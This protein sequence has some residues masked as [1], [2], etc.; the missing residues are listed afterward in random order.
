M[1]TPK[2]LLAKSEKIFF[3]VVSSQ[4]MGEDIFPLVIP[5]NKEISGSNYSDWKN[6]LVPLHQHS[7]AVKN[8]GYSVDWKEKKYKWQ[9]SDGTSK[10]LLRFHK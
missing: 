1:I 4:L 7:K 5:A 2:E 9:P 8:K 6:D 10:N 3:K